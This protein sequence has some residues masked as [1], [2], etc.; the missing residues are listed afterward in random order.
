MLLSHLNRRAGILQA[1]CS[2]Q[3]SSRSTLR[4]PQ[5]RPLGDRNFSHKTNACERA[6]RCHKGCRKSVMPRCAGK[7]FCSLFSGNFWTL[8]MKTSFLDSS[9][10][11]SSRLAP[12]FAQLDKLLSPVRGGSRHSASSNVR[13]IS[14]TAGPPRHQT[15]QREPK[16]LQQAQEAAPAHSTNGRPPFK[17]SSQRR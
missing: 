2:S 5:A 16:H 11:R 6:P 12:G 1:H 3:V 13:R 15:V 4:V 10:G 9:L 8:A 14:S 17:Q 7:I